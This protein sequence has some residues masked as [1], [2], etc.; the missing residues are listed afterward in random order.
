MSTYTL[1]S[2]N[3]CMTIFEENARHSSLGETIC[4]PIIFG[5]I[6]IKNHAGKIIDFDWPVL[7]Q[8]L[9]SVDLATIYFHLFPSLQNALNGKTV[10]QEDQR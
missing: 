6:F 10:S 4:F 8:L 3:L 5:A 1:S 7:Q 2:Q 9:Y